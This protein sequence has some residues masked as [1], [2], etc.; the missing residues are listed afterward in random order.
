MI[1][2]DYAI[3]NLGRSPKRLALVVGGSMLVSL[4]VLGAVAFARGMD[5]ALSSSGLE[6]NAL[7]IGSGSEES[8]ERSE[9]PPPTAGV[10][11]ASIDGLELVAGVPAV[12]PE[13]QVA[14][15]VVARDVPILTKVLIAEN[16]VE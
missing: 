1:L 15:P 7:L 5:R 6:T 14:L 3:R 9:I 2:C 12:S 16:C 10:L 4:L 8:V 11:A 13:I